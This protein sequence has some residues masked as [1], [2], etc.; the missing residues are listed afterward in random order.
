[1]LYILVC[2]LPGGS[3]LEFVNTTV[4]VTKTLFDAKFFSKLYHAWLR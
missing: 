3:Y 4:Y 2:L 1:M